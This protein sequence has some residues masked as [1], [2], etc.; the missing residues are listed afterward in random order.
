MKFTDYRILEAQSPM[1]LQKLVMAKMEEGYELL[2]ALVIIPASY[3]D[4]YIENK[5][6]LAQAMEP[7]A[8]G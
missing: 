6:N 1:G 2:G 7:Q 4:A 5:N 8:L 3:G